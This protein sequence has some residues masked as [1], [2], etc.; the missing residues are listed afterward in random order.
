[1]TL[2]NRI[3][4]F[5]FAGAWLRGRVTGDNPS[6]QFVKVIV[7]NDGPAYAQTVNKADL[8]FNAPFASQDGQL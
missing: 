4:W 3:V 5:C 1:M 8:Q 2:T 6:S 7:D